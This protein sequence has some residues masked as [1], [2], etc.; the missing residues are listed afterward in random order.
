MNIKCYKWVST[1]YIT[2][3]MLTVTQTLKG[4]KCR[5]S[6][7]K[8][9]IFLR[10]DFVQCDLL[11]GALE[12]IWTQALLSM[13][14][15][16]AWWLSHT[17]RRCWAPATPW[18]TH[19]LCRSCEADE[20]DQDSR[21]LLCLLAFPWCGSE[22]PAVTHQACCCVLFQPCFWVKVATAAVFCDLL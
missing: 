1:L 8:N 20:W 19:R 18:L 22:P 21:M 10:F 3:T 5:K 14:D 7:S 16:K 4:W 9:S 2:Q 17:L 12:G 13:A 6:C 15:S 11:T